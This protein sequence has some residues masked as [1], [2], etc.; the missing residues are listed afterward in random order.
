MHA[1]HFDDLTRSLPG[2]GSRGSRRRAV[3]LALSG[4]LGLA[5]SASSPADTAAKKKCPPCKKRKKGKCKKNKPNGT[6]CPGG[7]CQHGSCCVP[8]LPA[9]TCAGRCGT[10]T[11]TCRQPV[12]CPG[13][14]S[15]QDCL[16]NGSCT[17][18][19]AAQGVACGPGCLCSSPSVEGP[20]RCIESFAG[21]AANP[22]ACTSTAEC[23]RGEHC[24]NVS[25]GASSQRCVPLCTS[26]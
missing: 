9:A 8:E 6:I 26:V 11:N 25:C 21:C 12:V 10:W 7:T 19:C 4:A 18:T 22:Q 23:P 2:T 16:S 14:P 3:A 17:L 24:Q 15:G 5:L 20:N 1:P 13:C